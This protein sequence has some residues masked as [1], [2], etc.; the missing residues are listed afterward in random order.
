MTTGD[1]QSGFDWKLLDDETRPLVEAATTRLH[2]LER[3]TGESIVEIGR[4]LIEVKER[5]GYGRFGAWL[6]SEFGWGQSTAS[7][8]VQVAERFGTLPNLGNFAP[9]AL[10]ALASGNVPNEVRAEFIGRAE[11]GHHITHK[12]VK[13]RL[14][15]TGEAQPEA[16]APHETQ[17]EA[18]S[19][20]SVSYR[21]EQR[22]Q[23]KAEQAQAQ[24]ILYIVGDPEGKIARAKLREHFIKARAN[25]QRDLLGLDV[26]VVASA[27]DRDDVVTVEWFIRDTRNWLSQ[28]ES[29]MRRGVRVVSVK[30]A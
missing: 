14:V 13:S 22:D 18:P 10:M 21:Q 2:E 3:R 1:L 30:G 11:S 29:E 5:L 19:Q 6:D 20:V 4:T 7:R 8:F 24:R 23:A 12:D 17:P 27:L 25:A 26:E 9:S 15:E 28:L 16:F